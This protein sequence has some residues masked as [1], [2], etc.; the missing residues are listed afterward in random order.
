[1]TLVTKHD[2]GNIALFSE[3]RIAVKWDPKEFFNWFLALEAKDREKI[4]RFFQEYTGKA[5]DHNHGGS[6]AYAIMNDR[7]GGHLDKWCKDK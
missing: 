4:T 5:A 1:M 2:S 7:F 6:L 3:L